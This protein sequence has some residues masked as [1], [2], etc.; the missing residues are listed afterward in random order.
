VWQRY[1]QYSALVEKAET[2]EGD[3]GEMKIGDDDG[4]TIIGRERGVQSG[5]EDSGFSK[6]ARGNVKV[7]ATMQYDEPVNGNANRTGKRQKNEKD[8]KGDNA[9]MK[10]AM[11]LLPDLHGSTSALKVDVWSHHYTHHTLMPL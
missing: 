9:A 8:L 3:G 10:S 5:E 1:R 7:E 2:R 11:A 4:N 6:I